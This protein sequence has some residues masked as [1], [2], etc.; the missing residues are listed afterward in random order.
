MPL[1]IATDF[2]P[3][4]SPTRSMPLVMT[5]ACV[6]YGFTAAQA[7]TA[8]T[9]N[10]AWA[11]GRGDRL[12]VLAPGFQADLVALDIPNVRYLPYHFG[13]NF[14]AVVVKRGAVVVDRRR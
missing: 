1:A 12:G 9:V 5:F 6:R 4:S 7:L 10:A 3:G 2:N 8:A 11:I 14:A 13:E